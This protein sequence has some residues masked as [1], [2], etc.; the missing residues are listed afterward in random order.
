MEWKQG[1][2]PHEAGLVTQQH[3]A[4]SGFR[5]SF[6]VWFSPLPVWAQEFTSS[7]FSDLVRVVLTLSDPIGEV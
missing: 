4:F 2:S 1:V 3:L 7:S 6:F 5:A